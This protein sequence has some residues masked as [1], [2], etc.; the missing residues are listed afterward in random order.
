M[1][2]YPLSLRCYLV[3]LSVQLMSSTKPQSELLRNCAISLAFIVLI[4]IT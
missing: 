2:C 3:N 1:A 4:A